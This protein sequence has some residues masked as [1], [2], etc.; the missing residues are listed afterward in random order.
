[1][2][3]VGEQELLFVPLG[4]VGEIGMNLNLYGY[5]PREDHQ[6]LMID[7]GVAFG[8]PTMPGI[9]V[10]MADPSFI[11]ERRDNLL[12]LVLTHAHEDHLGAVHHLWERL[13][14]PVWATPFTARI[15]DRKLA[16]ANLRDKVPVTV[17][18]LGSRFSIGPFDIESIALTHSIPEPMAL[19]IRTPAGTVTHTGDWKLDPDPVVGGKVDEDAL[20]RLGDEGVLA[21]VCDSTNVLTPGTSGSE[22][23]LLVGLVEAIRGASGRVAVACFAS[24]V[25]RL[26]TIAKAAR[27][28][29]RD[30]VVA[31]RSLRRVIEAARETGYLSEAG[32]FIH[33]EDAGHLPKDKTLIV[34]TGSQ[35]EPRAALSRM[36]NDDHNHIT[37]DRGDRVVFSSRVIPGNEVYI[38]NLQNALARKGCEIVTRKD[39]F[40]HVSGHP[41]RDELTTMYRY[42]RPQ[43]AVPVHGEHRHLTAHA[44]LAGECGVNRAFVLENG[45]VL[46][47]APGEPGVVDVA[48]AGRLALEGNRLVP[49]HGNLVGS[50]YRAMY[51]GMLVVTV[52][53]N[54]RGALHDEPR[55]T[56]SGLLEAEKGMKDRLFGVVERAVETMN[57]R[58]RTNDEAAAE[59]IRIAVRRMFRQVLNKKPM[60]AVHLVRVR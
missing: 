6:W 47:L 46:K 15:L 9:D 20:E 51:N 37:L 24:N 1:M 7:L 21:I 54:A 2:T 42:I 11:E 50:R 59:I 36:A 32:N 17:T 16:E 18:P 45:H 57:K 19:A 60:T 39:A 8:D 55:F 52:V 48:R 27:T 3:K 56:S 33:E 26:E 30:V 14:C 58:D 10:V 41:A 40:V 23:D 5:G 13:R 25:A 4:G 34:C 49:L 31:G 29:G 44:E 35:G 12:G 53:L 38:N 28:H 22:A 43:I